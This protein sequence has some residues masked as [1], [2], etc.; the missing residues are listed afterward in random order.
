MKI[1]DEIGG[2]NIFLSFELRDWKFE[3]KDFIFDL[4]Q[5][6]DC[7]YEDKTWRVNKKHRSYVIGLIEQYL[8]NPLEKQNLTLDLGVE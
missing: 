4:K 3:W 2:D 5:L 8:T 7:K 6:P 1:V